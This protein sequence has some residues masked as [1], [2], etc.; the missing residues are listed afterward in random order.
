VRASLRFETAGLPAHNPELRADTGAKV[1]DPPGTNGFEKKV[2]E[3]EKKVRDVLE[4]SDFEKVKWPLRLGDLHTRNDGLVGLFRCS[5][6]DT[7]SGVAAAGLLYPAWGLDESNST[8]AEVFATQDFLIDC[9]K[10]LH[11][12]LL[13]DPQARVH[14]TTGTLP[15]VYRE[16]PREDATGAKRA[17]EVFFQTAPVLG[18]SPTPRMPRPS[19]DYGEW[20]WAYQPDVT[21]WKLDPNLVEATD[22]GGFA[23]AWPTI[24]EGWLK[25]AIAQVKVLSFWVR[26]GTEEV[27]GG[28]PIHLAW[29]LQAAESLELAKVKL[30]D[31]EQ[32]VGFVKRWDAP[33]FPRE[34]TVTVDEE[35]TYRIIASAAD[36]QPDARDLTVKIKQPGGS[37]N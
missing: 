29:S 21:H 16:L 8:S 17:R 11:V 6:A 4:T 5:P 22:R 20:S 34:Y 31:G 2:H 15:R 28:T 14:A 13:M 36:A 1:S 12:A 37:I 24:A 33:P 26:E 30:K 35:T 32:A 3:F 25:L 9:V 10:P 7:G 18:P 19:D 23:N 27:S